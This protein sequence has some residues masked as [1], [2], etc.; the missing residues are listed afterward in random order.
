[1]KCST[2]GKEIP[3]TSQVCPF[4]Y[5]TVVKE[6][7]QPAPVVNEPELNNTSNL[8]TINTDVIGNNQS[9][10][11]ELNFGDLNNTSYDNNT[12]Q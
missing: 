8:T 6:E 3:E 12:I 4:C 5:T 9:S 2:C 10:N 11:S 7:I 1:M